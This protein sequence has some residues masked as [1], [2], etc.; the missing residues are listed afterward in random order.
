MKLDITVR[1]WLTRYLEKTSESPREF[2]ETVE[3][4]LEFDEPVTLETIL[5]KLHIPMD[6]CGVVIFN[7]K[8]L[9]DDEFITSDGNLKIYPPILGG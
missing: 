8:K 2:H 4:T 7:Q 9:S 1:P 5:N 3:L 6:D